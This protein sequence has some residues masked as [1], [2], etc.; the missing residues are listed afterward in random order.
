MTLPQQEVCERLVVVRSRI[1]PSQR[2]QL[3][4]EGTLT[5]R[6]VRVA[7]EQDR[8]GRDLG[9][10]PALVYDG[11]AKAQTA[12]RP[13]LAD[14]LEEREVLGEAAEGDVLPVVGRR[15]RIAVALGKRLHGAAER[16]PGFQ[17]GDVVPR[18]QQLERR[19]AA[20]EAAA[21]DHRLHRRSPAPTI[22]SFVSADRCGGP[23]KTPKPR[24][25]IRSSVAR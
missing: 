21:D 10:A 17:Q 13:R 6:Q 9:P 8:P 20:R 16:R 3:P 11:K 22:R 4:D 19:R 7:R 23:S 1:D 24:A 2:K 12:Y 5:Q 14:P 25:S 18:V 15:R